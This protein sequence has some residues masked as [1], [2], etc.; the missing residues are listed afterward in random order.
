MLAVLLLAFLLGLVHVGIISPVLRWRDD[1]DRR[2]AAAETRLARYHGLIDEREHWRQR[3]A[4]LRRAEGEVGLLLPGRT[5]ALA[6]AA[7]QNRVQTLAEASA[8]DLRSLQVMAESA[9]E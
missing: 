8:V 5:R 1:L 6:A 2:I 4:A 9:P 3:L 7:L